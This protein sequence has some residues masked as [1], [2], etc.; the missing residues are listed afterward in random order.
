M[1]C[2]PVKYVG[3]RTGKKVFG[4]A[5]WNLAKT[6]MLGKKKLFC[7]SCCVAKNFSLSELSHLSSVTKLVG[8]Y[9]GSTLSGAKI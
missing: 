8:F 7:N 5:Q 6:A 4:K 2:D 3:D 9:S 1:L